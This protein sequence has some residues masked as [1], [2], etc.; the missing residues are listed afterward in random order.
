MDG[1]SE[2]SDSVKMGVDHVVD[3]RDTSL[4]ESMLIA[5]ATTAQLTVF[6]GSQLR[7]NLHVQDYCDA[8]QVLLIAPGEKFSTKLSTRA[9]GIFRLRISR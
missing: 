7:P 5:D 4:W 2:F 9:T 1:R 8:V 6:G 3:S